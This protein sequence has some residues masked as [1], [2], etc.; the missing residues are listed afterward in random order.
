MPTET[1]KK[2]E[3]YDTVGPSYDFVETFIDSVSG[4][5]RT[6]KCGRTHYAPSGS[7]SWEQ[8][9]LEALEDGC[10]RN[11]D[12]FIERSED[13]VRTMTIYGD[14]W[15]VGCP[16]NGATP[17]ERTIRALAPEILKYFKAAAQRFREAAKRM[18]PGGDLDEIVKQL[19]K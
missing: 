1:K 5:T 7:W 2:L 14:E 18:D 16:C 10:K 13:S 4:C 17:F 12:A 11:P 9:E 3:V 6:C 15:V 19:Q 8:G